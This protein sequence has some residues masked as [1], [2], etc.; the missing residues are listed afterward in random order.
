MT[1]KSVT[2]TIRAWAKRCVPA[3]ARGWIRSNTPALLDGFRSL[4][5]RSCSRPYLG[6][7]LAY[8]RG[9]AIVHRL[10][11]EGVFEEDLGRAMVSDLER[12]P[13]LFLDVGA[14]IG[15][16]S[17]YVLSR[18]PSQKIIA[19]E[20]GPT[21]RRYLGE[22]VSR[23]GLEDRVTIVDRAVGAAPGTHE[24]IVHRGADIGKDGLAD[25]GRGDVAERIVVEVGTLDGWW[26]EA[27]K[28][29][30]SVVKI[31][32]EGAE[33][34]VI[35]GA[36]AVLTEAR[37]VVFFELEEANLRAYP[38]TAADVVGVFTRAGYG[39]FTLGGDR[40]T[41]ENVADAAR[42]ADTFRAAPMAPASH[43]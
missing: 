31:D 35:D 13:G 8:N 34:L 16:M 9:N 42:A 19:F 27:G 2:G 40:V 29:A 36:S 15:L 25:T 33:K 18:R 30:V 24:F 32:T 38:Y 1:A 23:N 6:F 12:A 22:T 20:P 17:L 3:S 28:P 41:A 7:V 4:G 26:A 11:R 37:P 14:N 39:V 43:L 5:R 21:Q 10:R